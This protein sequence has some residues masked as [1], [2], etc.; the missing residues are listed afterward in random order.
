[1]NINN[2]IKYTLI[3]EVAI[4]TTCKELGERLNKDYEGKNP[5]F[6]VLLKGAVCFSINLTKYI[7]IPMEY[8]YMKPTSYDGTK[9][10]GKV[11]F[12]VMPSLDLNNRHVVIVEDIVDSGLTLSEVDKLLRKTYNLASLEVICLLDKKEM[13]KVEYSPKYIG[14]DIP[15]EFVVG[16]GLDYNEKYRNLPYI[17]VLKEEVYNK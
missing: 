13:R 2:D 4:E 12:K 1:M 6:L 8:D 15:N 16:Y 3:D 9:S 10:T 17:G 11:S 14:F 7:T 5:V